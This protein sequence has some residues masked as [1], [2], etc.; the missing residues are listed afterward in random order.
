MDNETVV[1]RFTWASPPIHLNQSGGHWA[2]KSTKVADVRRAG[3]FAAV[4]KLRDLEHV[5]AQ[6]VWW[7]N[8]KT[9]RDTDNVVPTLKA[10]CDGVVDAGV[11][12]DDNPRYMTKPEVQ[13][14]YR[15]ASEG[16][17][18]MELHLTP[19]HPEHI[20]L[21]KDMRTIHAARHAPEC[22]APGCA[23]AA[24]VLGSVGL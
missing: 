12:K 1:L 23:L 15:H 11:V 3:Y 19:G 17:P 9:K 6:L 22:G 5:T 24:L 13:I 4:N 14:R 7:V 16:K 20:K 8:T 18:C 10:L 21:A 2:K